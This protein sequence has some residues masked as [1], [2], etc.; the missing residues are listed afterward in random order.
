[1]RSTLARVRPV[2]LAIEAAV[3]FWQSVGKNRM[4]GNA[5]RVRDRQFPEV[6]AL[7]ERCVQALQ[8]EPPALYVSP[9]IGP[10]EVHTLG[11]SDEAAIVLGSGLRDHLSDEEMVS[12]IGHECGH[13]QNNHTST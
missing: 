5:V 2:T 6:N 10:L 13:I 1:M 4:L 7:L 11:T 8:I 9:S 12:V 3:R